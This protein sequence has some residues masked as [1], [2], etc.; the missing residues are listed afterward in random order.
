MNKAPKKLVNDRFGSRAKLVDEILNL[1]GSDKDAR[2]PARLKATKNGQLLRLHE[3]LTLVKSEFGTKDKLVDAIA[4]AKFAPNKPDADY[5]KKISD[6][7]QKRLLDLYG[8][9]KS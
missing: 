6:Y 8:Q 9:V 1:L 3:V 5:T 4:T 7:S 2:T